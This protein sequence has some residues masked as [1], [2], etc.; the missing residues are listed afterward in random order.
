MSRSCD[1]LVEKAGGEGARGN[2][3][4]TR[5]PRGQGWMMERGLFFTLTI[6]PRK[7]PSRFQHLGFTTS[8]IPSSN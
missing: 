4:A 1:K 8:K 6:F 2:W 5:N 7:F 3:E